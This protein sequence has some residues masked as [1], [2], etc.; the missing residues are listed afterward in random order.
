MKKI[1]LLFVASVLYCLQT[2]INYT[3]NNYNYFLNN[4]KQNLKKFF[5]FFMKGGKHLL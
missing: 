5:N 1:V 4:V 2:I 3:I